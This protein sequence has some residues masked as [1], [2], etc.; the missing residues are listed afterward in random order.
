V[1]SLSYKVYFVLLFMKIHFAL[2]F[3]LSLSFLCVPPVSAGVFSNDW[4]SLTSMLDIGSFYQG[5]HSSNYELSYSNS[6]I[7]RAGERECLSASKNEQIEFNWFVVGS[8]ATDTNTVSGL[9]KSGDSHCFGFDNSIIRLGWQVFTKSDSKTNEN[10]KTLN[11]RCVDGSWIAS[12][13]F[14][15]Q[16]SNSIGVKW[17]SDYSDKSW[18]DFEGRFHCSKSAS[19]SWCGRSVKSSLTCQEAGGHVYNDCDGY[20]E[21]GIKNEILFKITDGANSGMFCCSTKFT[22]YF[23]GESFRDDKATGFL[24]TVGRIFDPTHSLI[25]DFVSDKFD[26]DEDG[27]VFADLNGDGKGSFFE[28]VEYLFTGDETSGGVFNEDGVLPVGKLFDEG[29]FVSQT[30]SWVKWI[31]FAVLLFFA[32]PF[33]FPIF[34]RWLNVIKS[35]I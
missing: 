33:I 7:L 22:N 13:Y 11:Y 17:C 28:G 19:S 8:V 12:G 4:N 6:V 9:I 20:D 16:Y 25:F 30:L 1:I 3:F 5:E 24:E 31:L 10:H 35:I 23:G 18:E 14:D 2:I 21:Y 15:E 27:S 29:S 34:L 32:L 26:E